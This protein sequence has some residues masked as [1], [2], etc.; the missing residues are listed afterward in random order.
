MEIFFSS[1]NSEIGRSE[2]SLY[3]SLYKNYI[4]QDQKGG[5]SPYFDVSKIQKKAINTIFENKKDL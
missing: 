1:T 2:C 5:K 3:C 4:P